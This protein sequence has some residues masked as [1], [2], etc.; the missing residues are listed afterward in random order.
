MGLTV[1]L[2]IDRVVVDAE[3]IP[4]GMSAS[5]FRAGLERAIAGRLECGLP[6]AART[7]RSLAS[8]DGGSAVVAGQD[9]IDAI[10]ARVTAALGMVDR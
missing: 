6:A 5:R 3:A 7:T 4:A 1:R 10:A 9:A 2:R 8:I